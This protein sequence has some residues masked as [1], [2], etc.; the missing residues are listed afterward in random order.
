[1]DG[2]GNTFEKNGQTFEVRFFDASSFFDLR[3]LREIVQSPG[4]QS[5]MTSVRNMSHKHYGK[6]M[7]EKGEGYNF[8]FAIAGADA[9][10]PEIQRVHGFIYI[11][12]SELTLG[13]LEVSYAKRPGA[14][15]GLITPALR[16]AYRVVKETMQR[17]PRIIAEIERGN[18]ASI[19]AIERAG[20]VKTRDFDRYGNGIWTL[21]W[22]KI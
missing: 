9:D 10:R 5:W 7:N 2:T 1:M 16:V 21:D 17:E 19:I 15:G 14:P 20:F 8:L 11:Y 3:D 13:A 4:V 6:W 22:E 12:P 18:E